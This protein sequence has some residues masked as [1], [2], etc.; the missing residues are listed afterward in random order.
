MIPRYCIHFRRGRGQHI[1]PLWPIFDRLPTY[2]ALCY[3]SLLDVASISLHYKHTAAAADCSGPCFHTCLDTVVYDDEVVLAPC[4][5]AVP[6]EAYSS[7]CMP[8]SSQPF[9]KQMNKLLSLS[10][11]AVPD[12]KESI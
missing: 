7:E 4:N 2:H 8:R 1:R 3:D 9:R 5:S 10:M 11:A 6:W 12:V